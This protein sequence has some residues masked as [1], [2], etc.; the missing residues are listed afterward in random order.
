MIKFKGIIN[1]NEIHYK[2]NENEIKGNK[3]M[4]IFKFGK[5]GEGLSV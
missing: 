2:K 3:N 4:Q 1:E 5:P